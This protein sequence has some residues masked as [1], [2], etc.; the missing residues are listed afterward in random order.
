[1]DEECIEMGYTG[2]QSRVLPHLFQDLTTQQ[3]Q[4][5]HE[6][7]HTFKTHMEQSDISEEKTMKK[8]LR[9]SIE[10]YRFLMYKKTHIG[11]ASK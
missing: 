8:V 1:M 5:S 7:S 9:H 2:N 3:N 4:K 10:K 6:F 11:F